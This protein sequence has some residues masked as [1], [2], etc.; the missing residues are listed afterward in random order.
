[1]SVK[2]SDIAS[3]LFQNIAKNSL[4]KQ[5]TR[6][7]S[8]PITNILPCN[9]GNFINGNN[10][11]IIELIPHALNLDVIASFNDELNDTAVAILVTINIS[12]IPSYQTKLYHKYIANRQY[13]LITAYWQ[14]LTA[15]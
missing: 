8:I 3:L 1:M 2:S 5:N 10:D 9:T 4:A 13:E 12:L 15:I 11:I 7:H 6:V 14:Q